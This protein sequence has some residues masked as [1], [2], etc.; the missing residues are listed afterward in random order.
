M[1]ASTQAT[2]SLG[3]RGA[4]TAGNVESQDKMA[5]KET[6]L[7]MAAVRQE[8]ES[9]VGA[10]SL[11]VSEPV[12]PETPRKD[13]NST[14]ALGM[15]TGAAAPPAPALDIPVSDSV[16]SSDVMS[17]EA[18]IKK[19]KKK[20]K[21]APM[22]EPPPPPKSKINLKVILIIGA[23]LAAVGV[24][25]GLFTSFATPEPPVPNFAP[26]TLPNQPQQPMNGIVPPPVPP[27]P[28]PAPPTQPAPA[29]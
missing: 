8:A 5:F 21:A 27:P 14:P 3:P 17:D 6:V 1:Y 4:A 26:P 19:K 23:V 9:V 25:V 22:V 13:P 18:P 12:M 2:G 15:S 28:P 20:K 16:V 29:Q 24:G 7:G 11:P 10:P